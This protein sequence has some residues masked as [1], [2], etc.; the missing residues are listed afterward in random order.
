MK[1][2]TSKNKNVIYLLCV[3]DVFSKYA[4]V[5]PLKRKKGETVLN[6]LLK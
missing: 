6:A 3:A 5:K 2:L 4:W 1:L